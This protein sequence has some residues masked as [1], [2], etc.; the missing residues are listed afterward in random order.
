MTTDYTIDISKNTMIESK[1]AKIAQLIYM[2]SFLFIGIYFFIYTLIKRRGLSNYPLGLVAITYSITLYLRI[3]GKW[4]YKRYFSITANSI[5]WQKHIFDRANIMWSTI[6]QISF[7][8]ASIDF[9]LTTNKIKSFSL[10]YITAQQIA[11][12]NELI[13]QVSKEKGIK[14]IAG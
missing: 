1:E 14:Y 7:K 3:K 5:K 6:D 13:S 8:Y 11:E 10:G 12:L 4:I 2:Y 9:H